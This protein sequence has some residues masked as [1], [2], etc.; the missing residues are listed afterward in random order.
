LFE[1]SNEVINTG[2]PEIDTVEKN[3]STNILD[4]A[5]LSETGTTLV[6]ED[7]D[8]LVSEL[9]NIQNIDKSEE[10]DTIMFG[11]SANNTTSSGANKLIPF[12][13]NNPF[14]DEIL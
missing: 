1:Y 8:I 10:N 3:F 13:P 4:Y 2:I 7:G 11:S 12:D 14:T 9:Y 6:D 5:I